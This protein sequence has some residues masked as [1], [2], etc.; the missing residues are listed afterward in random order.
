MN[1]NEGSVYILVNSSHP[2]LIKIGRTA[3]SPIARAQELSGT[4][5][6]TR[7][8]VAYSVLVNDCVEVESSMHTFFANQRHTDDREFFEVESAVAIDKLLEISRDKR[9]TVAGGWQADAWAGSVTY[10][11]IKVSASKNIYRIGIINKSPIY[12]SEENF[13]SAVIDVY[14]TFD[15][16]FF[17]ECDVVCYKE[18]SSV[19]NGALDGMLKVIDHNLVMLKNEQNT[20]FN[21]EK[22]DLRTLHYKSMMKPYPE[23]IFRNILTLLEPFSRASS[24]RFEK[25]IG[26]VKEEERKRLFEGSLSKVDRLLK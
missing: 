3:K 10:Y 25:R 24:L 9:L 16:N 21:N 5:T 13:K 1:G 26:L 18:F 6:P 22:Y 2:G 17:Y 7:F 4:G 12:L 23:A 20:L 11:C 15:P 19:D 14:N 8:V